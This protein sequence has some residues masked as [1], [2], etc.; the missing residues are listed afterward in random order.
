MARKKWMI[1]TAGIG[2]AYL[3]RNKKSR[4]KLMHQF[5]NLAVRSKK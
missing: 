1:A 3:M 5:Q 2:A 4:Q